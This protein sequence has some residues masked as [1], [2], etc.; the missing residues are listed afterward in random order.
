MLHMVV[1]THSAE[2]CAFRNEE[3]KGKLTGGIGAMAE[4]AAAKGATLRDGWAN[5]A[6]HTVFALF[7]APNAHVVDEV[8]RDAGLVGYTQS[9]VFAVETME[10]TLEAAAASD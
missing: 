9:R 3:N 10:T 1:N 4:A 6:S 2:S 7:E 8:L 5:M